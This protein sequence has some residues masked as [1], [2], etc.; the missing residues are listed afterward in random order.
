[1]QDS[2]LFSDLSQSS[3]RKLI[4]I[5]WTRVGSYVGFEVFDCIYETIVAADF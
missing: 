3:R 5:G 1:M 4:I 2:L